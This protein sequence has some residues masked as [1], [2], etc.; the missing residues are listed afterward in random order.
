MTLIRSLDT[1]IGGFQ[2]LPRKMRPTIVETPITPPVARGAIRR[3]QA[4]D[5]ITAPSLDAVS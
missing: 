5:G 4:Y 3:T 1:V 2:M